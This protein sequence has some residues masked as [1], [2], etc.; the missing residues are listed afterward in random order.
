MRVL[1]TR[2]AAGT[3]GLGERAR[4]FAAERQAGRVFLVGD[5]LDCTPADVLALVRPGRELFLA[6][7]LAPE[8][9]VPSRRGT[10]RWIDAES[11]RRLVLGVGEAEAQHYERGLSARL[12]C[13]RNAAARARAVHGCWS[14]ATP[15]ETPVRRLC[16][17]MG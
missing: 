2:R 8:E 12:E 7:L 10:V 6:Q 3:A 1:E 14:S 9:L 13:L 15:F 4:A 5:F 11:G 17:R 16:A